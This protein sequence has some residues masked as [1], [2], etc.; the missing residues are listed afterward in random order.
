MGSGHPFGPVMQRFEKP[1]A[2]TDHPQNPGILFETGK[3]ITKTSLLQAEI[4]SPVAGTGMEQNLGEGL[5]TAAE[6]SAAPLSTKG[7]SGHDPS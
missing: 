6:P 7:E 5:E 1:E 4:L 3:P 2:V